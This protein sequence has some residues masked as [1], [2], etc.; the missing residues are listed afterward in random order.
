[1]GHDS[2]GNKY[3]WS[4][5]NYNDFNRQDR[6]AETLTKLEYYESEYQ[7]LKESTSLLDSCCGRQGLL[8]FAIPLKVCVFIMGIYMGSGCCLS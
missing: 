1:M 5:D 7:R 4:G 8:I 2:M 6:H 3:D